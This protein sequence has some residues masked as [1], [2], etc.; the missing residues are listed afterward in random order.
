[1]RFYDTNWLSNYYCFINFSVC[2]AATQS[3]MPAQDMHILR[4]PL[5]ADL[6][7]WYAEDFGEVL[8]TPE[9]TFDASDLKRFQ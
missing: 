4:N 3:Y 2:S 5:N 6:S 9:W 1:M 7:P 8:Q